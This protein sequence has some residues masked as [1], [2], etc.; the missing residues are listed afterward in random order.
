[1]ARTNIRGKIGN[2]TGVIAF[3][4]TI[5]GSTILVQM[6]P[7]FVPC[8]IRHARPFPPSILGED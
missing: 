4:Q 7:L 6:V 2:E 5:S 8:E 1:L 3:S